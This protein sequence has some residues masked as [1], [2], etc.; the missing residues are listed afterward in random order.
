MQE[1]LLRYL[2]RKVSSLVQGLAAA[3]RGNLYHVVF[4]A[5]HVVGFQDSNTRL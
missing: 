2:D 5:W 1:L 4:I 3:G